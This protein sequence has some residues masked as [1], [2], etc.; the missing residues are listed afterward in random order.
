MQ[1]VLRVIA[2]ASIAASLLADPMLFTHRRRIADLAIKHRLPLMGSPLGYVEAGGLMSYWS[3]QDEQYRR[4]ASYVDRILKAAK[5]GISP[6][7]S[8]ASTSCSSTSARRRRW[9]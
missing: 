5:P 1:P 7:S 4:V 9:A 3:D 8:R 6:S 2:A